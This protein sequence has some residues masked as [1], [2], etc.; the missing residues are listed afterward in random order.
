MEKPESRKQTD[1]EESAMNTD[2]L[3]NIANVVAWSAVAGVFVYYSQVA[4]REHQARQE[5]QN[6]PSTVQTSRSTVRS[7]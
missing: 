3:F 4:R 6:S 2:L 5:A 7:P 1:F